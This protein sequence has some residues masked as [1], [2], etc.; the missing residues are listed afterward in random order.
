MKIL[1]SLKLLNIT[2]FCIVYQYA[3][4]GFAAEQPSVA[5]LPSATLNAPDDIIQIKRML[6]SIDKKQKGLEEHLND[7]T[8]DF[9]HMPHDKRVVY[10][11]QAYRQ[12]ILDGWDEGN[13][14]MNHELIDAYSFPEIVIARGKVTGTWQPAGSK[15]K[16]PFETKNVFILKRLKNGKLK[17]WQII[18]NMTP[19]EVSHED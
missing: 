5:D 11:K 17:I 9:I 19:T 14:I 1:T 15:T 3:A 12:H 2:L 10:G 7:V 8:D 4:I 16:H 6:S 13:A 18:Y